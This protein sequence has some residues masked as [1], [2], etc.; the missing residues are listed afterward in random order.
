MGPAQ[1]AKQ[2]ED[3][4]SK[5]GS[6]VRSPQVAQLL[7]Q[8][9]PAQ[10][11]AEQKAVLADINSNLQQLYKKLPA[12]PNTNSERAATVQL[13]RGVLH[14]EA[15]RSIGVLQVW[16]QQQPQRLV[17]ALQSYDLQ[18]GTI[19]GAWY[20]GMHVMCRIAELLLDCKASRSSSSSTAGAALLVVEMTQQLLQSGGC[21]QQLSSVLAKAKL[22]VI[23][24]CAP[25]LPRLHAQQQR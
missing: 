18:L 9:L 7:Q 17:T 8:P 15:V 13:L 11:A 25:V 6:L 10:P 16:L 14:Q 21:I 5:L 22:H 4:A 20:A 2:A 19:E 12:N 24:S 1:R 3:A 23:D